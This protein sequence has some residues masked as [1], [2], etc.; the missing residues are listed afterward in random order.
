[1]AHDLTTIPKIGE[2]LHYLIKSMGLRQYAESLRGGTQPLD[3]LAKEQQGADLCQLE[4]EVLTQML[5]KPLQ[6]YCGGAW[7]DT[8]MTVVK[9]LLSDLRK[10]ARVWAVGNL[11]PL[12]GRQIVYDEYL[13]PVAAEVLQ[14]LHA[15][16]GG[17]N[18][19]GFLAHPF[20]TWCGWAEATLSS[21]TATW[22]RSHLRDVLRAHFGEIEDR[23]F[24]N[25]ESDHEI[26]KLFFNGDK[27]MKQ[28]FP[29]SPLVKAQNVTAWL[30]IARL[31]QRSSP[32]TRKYISSRL[33]CDTK[34][35]HDLHYRVSL[36][37][38]RAIDIQQHADL[39]FVAWAIAA[40]NLRNTFLEW[41]EA[42]SRGEHENHLLKE[43]LSATE[44]ARNDCKL[45]LTDASCVIIPRVRAWLEWDRGDAKEAMRHFH[46]FVDALWWCGGPNFENANQEAI[47]FAAGIGDRAEVKALWQKA[48][49]LGL[50]LPRHQALKDKDFSDLALPFKNIF[51]KPVTARSVRHKAMELLPI[52]KPLVC[53]EKDLTCDVVEGTGKPTSRYWKYGRMTPL[54]AHITW[55]SAERVRKLLAAGHSVDEVVKETGMTALH[56]ALWKVRWTGDEEMLN[57][58]LERKPNFKTIDQAYGEWDEKPL[59]TAIGTCRPD[60]VRGLLGLLEAK[61]LKATVNAPCDTYNHPLYATLLHWHIHTPQGQAAAKRKS[62]SGQWPAGNAMMKRFGYTFDSSALELLREMDRDPRKQEIQNKEAGHMFPPLDEEAKVGLREIVSFLLERGAD[63]NNAVDK[64]VFAESFTPTLFAAEI[65]DLELF[66]LL[67]EKGGDPNLSIDGSTGLAR[68]DAMFLASAYGHQGI[69][70]YLRTRQG[71]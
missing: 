13:L 68:K 32:M 9:D 67:V 5:K 42:R 44:R 50:N 60:I 12:Q 19:E 33:S 38:E 53:M 37:L 64:R 62:L 4:R 1:M 7:A 2:T 48:S 57:L 40:K 43:L 55:G 27:I 14:K 24:A 54:M 20:R 65:G 70:E 39:Q 69:A 26:E 25:W 49:F 35:R 15:T 56:C 21:E 16:H 23:T 22:E 17:P 10:M 36:S 18:L 3:K 58:V 6:A 52:H 29:A 34:D 59:W 51:G 11:P 8:F 63:P 28:I 47:T 41:C 45:A 46:E 30:I 61:E 31:L 71:Q 66:K